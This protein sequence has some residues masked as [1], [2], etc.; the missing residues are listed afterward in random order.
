MNLLLL[1]NVRGA[2]RDERSE[3]TEKGG[4]IALALT[5]GSAFSFFACSRVR[6]TNTSFQLIRKC[7]EFLVA[8]PVRYIEKRCLFSALENQNADSSTK[9]EPEEHRSQSN[10][11]NQVEANRRLLVNRGARQSLQKRRL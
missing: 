11:E 6:C 8:S 9:D 5:A 7:R 4:V 2:P 10:T 1:P 3:Q